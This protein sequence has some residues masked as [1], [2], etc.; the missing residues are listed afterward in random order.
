MS[1]PICGRQFR[2][3]PSH[4]ARVSV[5]C[6]SRGCA[7]E[8][9]KVRIE[10]HCVVCGVTMEQTPSD[11]ERVTV[12]SKL[13]SSIRR[14]KSDAPKKSNFAVYK[15]VADEIATQG[16]CANCG[17]KHGPWVVRGLHVSFDSTNAV[18]LDRSDASLWCR[19][20]HL[21]D[22]APSGGEANAQ[23]FLS[24]NLALGG[25]QRSQTQGE[26]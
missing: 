13:C 26:E 14:R 23:R 11:A 2:R 18:V 15:K 6:C 10:T 8:A 7:A 19:Q 4:A 9:R 1:C 16:L 3:P 17:A 25:V 20:C 21:K 22:V 24:P 5:N 12:C